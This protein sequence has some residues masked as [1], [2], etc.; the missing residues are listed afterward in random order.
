MALKEEL[1]TYWDFCTS[2]RTENAFEGQYPGPI[3]EIGSKAG[4]YYARVNFILGWCES[5]MRQDQFLLTNPKQNDTGATTGKGMTKAR[6]ELVAEQ[7]LDKILLERGENDERATYRSLKRLADS[8]ENI[9]SS[10]R[11]RLDG[12]EREQRSS[13]EGQK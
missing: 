5:R 8:L 11:L 6:A 12:L 13:G 3:S 2:E 7:M 10:A 9:R 4:V 1:K